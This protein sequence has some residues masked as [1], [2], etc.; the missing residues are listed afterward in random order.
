MSSDF[1]FIVTS[2]FPRKCP[3]KT[4]FEHTVTLKLNQASVWFSD[5]EY[6]QYYIKE[7]HRYSLTVKHFKYLNL[8]WDQEKFEKISNH[9]KNV[10]VD[11]FVKD[12]INSDKIVDRS[13][14]KSWHNEL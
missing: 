10:A 1:N 13:E 4:L 9:Y 7:V 11:L 5:Q 6:I 3:G 8:N 12:D 2:W 14:F